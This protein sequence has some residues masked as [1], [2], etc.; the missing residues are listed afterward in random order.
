MG[1][2]ASKVA[3]GSYLGTG[4]EQHVLAVGFTPSYLKIVDVTGSTVAEK[5]AG[6]NDGAAFILST[7]AATS[8]TEV[9]ATGNGGPEFEAGG[10]KLGTH[11]AVNTAAR[12][13]Y[14]LAVE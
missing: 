11:A 12:R 10:F 13:Y 2:G 8:T 5:F 1:S 6:A 9:V 4:A 3:M 7:L 14:Y